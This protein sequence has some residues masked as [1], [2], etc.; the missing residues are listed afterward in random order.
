MRYSSDDL[1]DGFR[2]LRDALDLVTGAALPPQAVDA[3]ARLAAA[4]LGADAVI[5]AERDPSGE[6]ATAA[7]WSRPDRPPD[8]I[9]DTVGIPLALT[10]DSAWQEAD[11]RWQLRVPVRIQ[12]RPWGSATA[13]GTRPVDQREL[14]AERFGAF[15][16]VIAAAVVNGRRQRELDRLLAEQRTLRRVAEQVATS[17]DPDEVFETVARE[18]GVLSGV[19]G[20][21]LLRYET[22]GTASF[23]AGWGPLAGTFPTGSRTTV[24]GTSVAGRILATGVP[25]RVD[26]YRAESGPVAAT[27][28]QAGMRSAVGVPI[29]VD[30][31]LWGAFILGSTEGPLPP[32]TEAR[33][34]EFAGLISSHIGNVVAR[35]ALLDSRVRLVAAADSAR[36]RF[37]RDLHDGVQQKLVAAALATTLARDLVRSGE[38]PADA[39]ATLDARLAEALEQLRDISRGIHPFILSQGGL[40]PALRGLVRRAGIP[41][42]LSLPDDLSSQDTHVDVAAYVV[43]SESLTNTVKHAFAT[44]ASVRV[45]W[46]DDM[47]EIITRDDGVGGA[48]PRAGTGL[49]G[50]SDRLEALGGSLTVSSPAGGGT[51][52]VA[53]MRSHGR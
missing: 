52:I 2:G 50:L 13:V 21:K 11:G 34:S 46:R 6:L 30:G 39:L 42:E 18:V 20:T 9:P 25:A 1:H 7:Q 24:A 47:L 37:E 49:S 22:D 29:R 28:A 31:R 44:E 5:V 36:E 4:S 40:A 48:D 12:G 53:R 45:S 51:T 3:L 8:R 15:A 17:S 41:V 43:I 16:A 27:L 35:Q 14:A 23:F 19:Q 38:D 26:D 10:P 32:D 33:L